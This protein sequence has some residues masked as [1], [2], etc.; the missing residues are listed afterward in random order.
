ML[1]FQRLVC[2]I[3]SNNVEEFIPKNKKLYYII[4][5]LSKE[6]CSR[7]GYHCRGG[8]F[9]ENENNL[10]EYDIIMALI[11]FCL[12][13]LSNTEIVKLGDIGKPNNNVLPIKSNKK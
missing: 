11:Y 13:T 9:V 8:F 4:E 1:L 12:S 5:D 10:P 6:N 3:I 2:S 7:F